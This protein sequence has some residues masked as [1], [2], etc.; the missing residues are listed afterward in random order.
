M[1]RDK[2]KQEQD[3]TA[4]DAKHAKKTKTLNI[5]LFK[6]NPLGII[7]QEVLT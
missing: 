5:D 7:H 3:L 1:L 2:N 6:L 4:K